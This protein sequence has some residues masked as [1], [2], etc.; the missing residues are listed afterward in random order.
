[1]VLYTVLQ[2]YS[3]ENSTW[4]IGVYA[5][6]EAAVERKETLIRESPGL[7]VDIYRTPVGEVPERETDV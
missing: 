5:S 1:M 7:W 2:G 4:L 3:F 6:K